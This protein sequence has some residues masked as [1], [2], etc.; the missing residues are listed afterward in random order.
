MLF[1]G[2]FTPHMTTHIVCAILLRIFPIRC[3]RRS[4]RPGQFTSTRKME[5]NILFIKTISFVSDVPPIT[6]CVMPVMY[7]VLCSGNMDD[8][9]CIIPSYQRGRLANLFA[10][11]LSGSD[12]STENFTAEGFSWR[13]GKRA[14][15]RACR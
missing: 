8:S 13:S 10:K 6:G 14:R 7:I 11:A 5:A 4:F 9:I 12:Q 15:L 3:A 2:V 1:V